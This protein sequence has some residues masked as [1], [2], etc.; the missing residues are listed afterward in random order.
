MFEILSVFFQ[1]NGIHDF[2]PLALSKC[3]VVRRYLLERAGIKETGTAVLFAVPYLTRE[4]LTPDRNLSAYAISRDY[5]LF[6]K[7][8]FDE[9]L[10]RLREAFPNHRFA[11]FA[12]HS[13]ID[14]VHAAARAGL[15]VIGK[16]GLLITE[17][18]SS[19]VFLGEIVTDMELPAPAHEISFC[20]NCGACKRVCPIADSELCL[21]ALTQKK[22]T[23][24]KEEAK[25]LLSMGSVWGCDRCQEVCP[26][27]KDAER[28]G[29]LYT[30]IPFFSD[31]P[32]PHL[33]KT[34]LSQMSDDEFSRRAYAWRGRETVLR[35]LA[36]IE[37]GDP[38]C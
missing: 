37:K 30:K 31:S 35:N 12:D 18:H 2:S 10:P 23:L 15:G 32:L 16:N 22:G 17:K 1:K 11:G 34:I 8:L 3:R 38:E 9:A 26:H 13:P 28:N 7:M 36:L 33:T 4:A 19:Y 14:E 24:T 5:H 6:F 29:T 27:T 20:K 25:T 21:S